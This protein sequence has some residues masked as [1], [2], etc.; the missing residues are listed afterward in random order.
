MAKPSVLTTAT[1][2]ADM[3]ATIEVI[4]TVDLDTAKPAS[5][6]FDETAHFSNK[7]CAVHII[8]EDTVEVVFRLSGQDLKRYKSRWLNRN[9]AEYIWEFVLRKAILGYIY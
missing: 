9:W 4:K 3:M 6:L 8:D 1:K 2:L 7:H 5:E